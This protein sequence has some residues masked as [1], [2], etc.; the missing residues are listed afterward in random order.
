M[1]RP[2][3]LSTFLMFFLHGDLATKKHQSSAPLKKHLRKGNKK[4]FKN[5]RFLLPHKTTHLSALL[6][7]KKTLSLSL[8]LNNDAF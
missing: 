8:S 6:R 7:Y 1:W 3:F 4:I 5:V 2:E